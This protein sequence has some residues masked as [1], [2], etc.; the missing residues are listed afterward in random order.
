MRYE[1]HAV[2]FELV[3]ISIYNFVATKAW[4]LL[5]LLNIQMLEISDV[6]IFY[7]E[8]I[9]QGRDEHEFIRIV[10]YSSSLAGF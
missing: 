3:I 2:C 9:F 6:H 5:L 10:Q 4:H 1:L 7:M 8:N